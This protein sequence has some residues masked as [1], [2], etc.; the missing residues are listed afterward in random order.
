MSK[1][2]MHMNKQAGLAQPA[3]AVPGCLGAAR[4]RQSGFTLVELMVV[5]A[6]AAILAAL[7][8][9]SFRSF[10][11]ST[12]Q[13]SAV[14]QLVSDLNLGRS[15]AIKRNAH[16]LVCARNSDGTDCA[17][18]TNWQAGWLVCLEGSVVNQCAAG[19]VTTPNPI[20][21]R[22]PLDSA[23]TLTF[24]NAV[25]PAATNARFNANS[26]QGSDGAANTLRIG[27]TWTG[28]TARTITVATTGNISKQ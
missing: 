5:V 13:S 25:T 26:S 4:G 7:A 21:V 2:L 19:T 10:I 22:P 17:A 8:V 28:A 1:L 23:L 18:S 20:V 9:P 3:R 6:I 11:N 12:R 14:M 27:G 16:V 15:E 24:S